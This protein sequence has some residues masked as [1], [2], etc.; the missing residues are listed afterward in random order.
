MRIMNSF[1][2]SDF[3]LG[4]EDPEQSLGGIAGI[5]KQAESFGVRAVGLKPSPCIGSFT[6]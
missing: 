4:R 1:P 3:D 5:I 6:I 2:F